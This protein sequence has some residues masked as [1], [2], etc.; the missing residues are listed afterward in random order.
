MPGPRFQ[1]LDS[2]LT[3]ARAKVSLRLTGGKTQMVSLAS[4][5]KCRVD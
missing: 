4:L 3:L 5:E 1:A 2:K